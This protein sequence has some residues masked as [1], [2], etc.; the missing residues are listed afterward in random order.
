MKEVPFEVGCKKIGIILHDKM[1]CVEVHDDNWDC[2]LYL[3]AGTS[4]H[5]WNLCKQEFGKH[6]FANTDDVKGWKMLL[7]D[8]KVN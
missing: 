8:N 4:W 5:H 1:P 3:F 7:E 6:G 2:H